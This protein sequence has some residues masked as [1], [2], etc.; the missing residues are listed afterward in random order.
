MAKLALTVP[1]TCL[2]GRFYG[3]WASLEASIDYS[4]GR[5]LKIPH[6]DTHILTAGMEF[7]RK[8]NLLRALLTRSDDPDRDKIKSL[9][10]KLQNEARRNI[11]THSLMFSD[12]NSVTFVHRRMDGTY[13]GSEIRFTGP[14]FEKHVVDITN[15][16][17]DLGRFLNIDPDD[18]QAF[19]R[20]ASSASSNDP[21]SPQPPSSKA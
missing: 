7:G 4:I 20:A 19:G 3:M 6:T 12:E 18:Y 14:E 1:F 17:R 10:T 2:V 9:L 5:L 8:A 21:K 11:F 16:A 13:T 15:L